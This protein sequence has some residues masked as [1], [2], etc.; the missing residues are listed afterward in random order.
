MPI[1]KLY[2]DPIGLKD[3]KITKNWDLVIESTPSHNKLSLTGENDPT[4]TMLQIIT[5]CLQTKRNEYVKNLEFG[6][7]PRGYKN[8]VMTAKTLSDIK[9]YIQTNLQSS[10]IN[11][12]DYPME[13]T[14]FPLTK[15]TIGV[16]V[17]M[18]L[19]ILNLEKE[20]IEV[21]LVFNHSTQEVRTVYNAF[22]G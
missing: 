11:Q 15:D 19:P 8:L 7:S 10:F 1:N 6:A 5:M 22:G 18:F 16:R 12:K 21:K 13:I 17:G 20:Q 9:S 14:I 2:Q 3:L 4:E